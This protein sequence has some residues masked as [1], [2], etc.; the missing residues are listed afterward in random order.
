M[1]RLFFVVVLSFAGLV[2]I[3]T[4]SAQTTEF[5]Y[6]GSLKDNA[7]PANGTYDFEFQLYD[8]ISGGTQIGSTLTRSTVN[9]TNGIF[10]TKLDFGGQFPGANRYLEIHVRVSG[11]PSFTTL[12]PR[13]LVNS[14]PYSI[15]SINAD[16]ATNATNA[17]TAQTAVSATN[18][19]NAT[20][21]T[22]AQT[23]TNFSGALSGDV[24]GLQS[25]TTIANNAVTTAKLA[26]DSVTDAK[27][28]SVGGG[29]VT[30]SITTATIPGAN[31]T[32]TVANATNATSSTNATT[33]A[34][35]TNALSLGGVA[36]NQ[37]VLTGDARLSDA[38]TPTAGSTNYIQNTTSAQSASFNVAGSGMVGSTFTF[39]P[40]SPPAVA[41]VGQGRFYFD[42]ATNK[43][44]VSEN[45]SAYVNLIGSG[46]IGSGTTNFVPVWNSS[47]TLGNSLI[48][49]SGSNVGIGT[50]TPT[51]RLHVVGSPADTVIY[52]NNLAGGNG[53][54]GN[55]ATGNGVSGQ[56]GGSFGI[57]VSGN[58]NTGVDGATFG[59][60]NPIA[61][62]GV[63]G[64]A[65]STT[66][67]THGVWGESRSD[68]GS[69]VVGLARSQTGSTIGVE[70]NSQSSSGTGVFGFASSST[71]TT[72]GVCGS[73]ASTAGRGVRGFS[74]GGIGV[75]GVSDTGFAGYFT[76]K[77]YFDG[78]VGIGT[79]MPAARLEVQTASGYGVYG[80][81]L[82][83]NPVGVSGVSVIPSSNFSVAF[84]GGAGVWGNTTSQVGVYGTSDTNYGVA[85]VSNLGG[86][87]YARSTGG[88]N[89]AVLDG[90]VQ[91]N[92]L[93]ST[94]STAVC[95]NASNQLSFC[96]SSLKYKTN[97][98]RFG[99]GLDLVQRLSPITFDW[100]QGGMHDLGLGAEDVAKIEP[101]LVSYNDKGQVEGVKYDRIGVVLVNAVK[102]Q[103]S[104]IES[105]QKQIKTQ[106]A[107]IDMQQKQ[108]KAQQSEIDAL[109]SLVC[110]RN[111]RAKVCRVKK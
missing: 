68:A 40:I 69:G 73:A 13:Q 34:T 111:R 10:S 95:R 65:E 59:P 89:A 42:S 12:T 80:L 100:K 23:A 93:G 62:I 107:E 57:G 44:K 70:G 94:G 35:A 4:V 64:H 103:Q 97:I 31:V 71:G 51:T 98:S 5:T 78:S 63:Y 15:K 18:A 90:T 86:G 52:G 84:I 6:Q 47:T 22:T 21:A 48:A 72:C 99:Y 75:N 83:N 105:Q 14:S 19:T 109:R 38:R 49:Q 82:A 25:S 39:G 37:Y 66:G 60:G 88:A 79:S 27:I 56:G 61:S 16:N 26:D 20:S 106:Q 54:R 85:A 28:N 67:D 104:Q 81:S 45:G 58:G 11:Q 41:S 29:K 108:A 50:A 110:A 32:G 8:A 53:V 24:N 92:Q 7:N 3:Q 30:G 17:T 101:L 96:S 87:L 77:S 36:A 76:G 43:I 1:N 91:V 9:V 74:S 46:S 2:C 102:E 55:S 33:A